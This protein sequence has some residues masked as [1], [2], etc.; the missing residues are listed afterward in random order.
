MTPPKLVQA[1][2][3]NVPSATAYTYDQ[4]GRQTAAIAYAAGSP[5]W[6]TTTSYGGNF[7]TTVPP[8]GGTATTTVTDARGNTTDLIQYHTGQPA[9]YLNDPPSDYS[10]TSYTY[11]PNGRKATQADPAGNTWSWKYNLLGDQTQASDPDTGNSSSTY[12][13]AGQLLTATDARGKQTTTTYDADGRVTATYDTTRT[14]TLSSANQLTGHTYDTLKKGLPTA[15]TSYSGGDTY[16]STVLAYNTMAEPSATRVTLTG[17][18]TT[19]VPAAGLVTSY[20]YSITGRLQGHQDPASGGLPAETITTGFDQFGEPTSLTGSGGVSADYVYATGYSEYG[21]PL[22]YTFGGT[23]NGVAATMTYDPQTRNLTNVQTT[24]STTSG[25][26]DSLSYGYSNSAVSTGAGLVT[27]ITDKQNAGAVTDTQ[28]FAYDYAQRVQAAWTATD[29]CAATPSPGNSASVGGPVAPYWQSWTYDAAGDRVT[30]TDHDTSG[31]TANDTTTAYSYPAPGSATD[32][33]H[34]L[35]GTTATGP[36]AAGD[37]ASYAYDAAG[38][39]TSVTGGA[40]GSQVLTW[41]SQDKLAADQTSA[42]TTSYVY[43]ASGNVVVR[44]DPGQTTFYMG[45][46]QIVLNT[47]AGTVSG[48][49]F[50]S[51]GG[52]TIAART[53]AITVNYLIPDRQGTDLLAVNATTQAVTRRQYLPFGAARGAV[54]AAWPGDRGYVGGSADTA[55]SMETLG[56][57]QYDPATGR[58]LSA[59]PVFEA[60]DPQQVGGYDY[61]GNNPVTGSDPTGLMFVAPGGGGGCPSSVSGCPGYHAHSSSGG[62]GGGGCGFLG[63]G[64]VARA[65]NTGGNWLNR[66]AANLGGGVIN[67]MSDFSEFAATPWRW[68]E[69]QMLNS[70][71]TGMTPSG[72]LTFNNHAGDRVWK[73]AR[74]PFHIGDPRS[75]AYKVG[76]YGWPLLLPPAAEDDGPALLG[77]NTAAGGGADNVVNGVRLARQLARQSAESVFTSTGDLDPSVIA[78]SNL[79]IPGSKLGN[80][81]LID[82]LTSDGSNIADWG[83]YR[84]PNFQSPYGDFQVHFYMNRVTGT[85]DYGYDYKVIFNGPR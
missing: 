23:T 17:E 43:D 47:G 58:F 26:V 14:Q 13:N 68:F 73:P 79:I 54:P 72:Q 6:Q 52:T 78:D 8:S 50:Y 66:Q 40:A 9:D 59:D 2:A 53:S 57:R 29:G 64:C 56:A 1:Q 31:T 38:N 46:E 32:Q 39:T 22:Q 15:T 63:L 80:K 34:T 37:T 84:T 44:R 65:I 49:R 10:D 36:G 70:M 81:G 51:I 20:G 5:T 25:Y 18:G 24:D 60:S 69:S 83:K 74:S 41:N 21:Q 35:T 4:A 77:E 71:P 11:Y 67:G 3:G 33:P 42:G 12:D 75:I 45:D 82:A 19:L 85:V 7:V 48:T 27:G 16:T 76:Y 61:A 62:G 30:Q 28:C 55:T